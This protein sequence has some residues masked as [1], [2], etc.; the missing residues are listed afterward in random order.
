MEASAPADPRTPRLASLGLILAALFWGISYPLTKYVEN[1]PTFY[2]I[3]VRFAIA[4]VFLA[5]VCRRR[6]HLIN[7]DTVRFALALSLCIAAM[8]VLN[9]VGIKYTTSVR[10]SFFTTL[11]YLIV[12]VLNYIFYRIRI[13]STIAVSAAICTVGMLMLCYRP[14]MGNVHINIGDILCFLASVAG[15]V[16]IIFVEKISHHK[17][18]DNSLFMVFMMAFVSCIG[19]VIS[20]FRGELTYTPAGPELAAIIVMGLFCSAGAFLL[21][22]H[23]EAYVPSNRVGIIFSL[24]PASGCILSVLLIHEA[25]SLV[26]WA[27]AGVIMLSIFYL[28]YV[29]A[30]EADS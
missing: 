15:A 18:I 25:M 7:R 4:T 24:E 22:I 19:V 23:C 14:D 20:L 10:A 11:S 30:K 2:I 13:S 5:V 21:Q 12:P 8:Y 27:G 9:I 16:N 3:A 6:F 1:C 26:G 29:N 28:E 17:N